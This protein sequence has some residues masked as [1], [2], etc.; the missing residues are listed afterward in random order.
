M[1]TARLCALLTVALLLGIFLGA[2]MGSVGFGVVA[3][4]GLSIAMWLAARHLHARNGDA[5]C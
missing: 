3:G 5:R 2:L 1:K 4:S